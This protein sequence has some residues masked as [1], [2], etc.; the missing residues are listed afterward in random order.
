[1]NQPSHPRKYG[2][3]IITPCRIGGISAMIGTILVFPADIIKLRLQLKGESGIKFSAVQAF[4]EIRTNEGFQGFFRALDPALFRQ[5]TSGSLRF[6]VYR[7]MS[8]NIKKEQKRELNVLERIYLSLVSGFVGGVSGT[9]WEIVII[10]SQVNSSLPLHQRRNYGN[11]F[12]A[13]YRVAKE[14]GLRTLWKG[15]GLAIFSTMIFNLG[16]LGSYDAVKCK[17]KQITG[18]KEDTKEIRILAS[19]FAGAL[20]SVLGLPLDNI[21]MKLQKTKKSPNEPFLYNGLLDCF[22]KSIKRE[23]IAGLWIGLPVFAAT[24]APFTISTLLIQDF[25]FDTMELI[26]AKSY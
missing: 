4:K 23:G 15:S 14:E 20:V 5:A 8:E 13:M 22:R 16:M 9:P 11:P 12:N 7:I 25:L 18:N 21:K 19:G 3:E 26:Q 17:L 10:R 6:G 2:Y 24:Y 1:M